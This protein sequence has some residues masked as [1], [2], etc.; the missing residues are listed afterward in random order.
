MTST[1][2]PCFKAS[3]R[4]SSSSQSRMAKHSTLSGRRLWTVLN[5]KGSSRAARLNHGHWHLKPELFGRGDLDRVRLGKVDS[6]NF[7]RVRLVGFV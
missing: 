7:D 2:S 1:V 5:T 3:M 6:V 4:G